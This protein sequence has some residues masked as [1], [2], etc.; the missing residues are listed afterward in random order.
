MGHGL[1]EKLRHQPLPL[2]GKKEYRPS[3]S[4]NGRKPTPGPAVTPLVNYL[5]H[6][7]FP[8]AENP[9]SGPHR[10]ILAYSPLKLSPFPFQNH[11]K[12]NKKPPYTLPPYLSDHNAKKILT[13][14]TPD[15]DAAVWMR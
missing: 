3:P 6:P 10:M 13:N 2:A 7:K 12:P 15:F 8:Q 5:F 9:P 14:F 1:L 11:L 4:P